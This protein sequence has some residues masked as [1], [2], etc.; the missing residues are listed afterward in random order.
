MFVLNTVYV[1]YFVTSSVVC[2]KLQ[3]W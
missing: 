3:Y 2:F 1:I